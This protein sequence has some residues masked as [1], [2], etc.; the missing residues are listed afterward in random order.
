M[1]LVG[2]GDGDGHVGIWKHG[3]DIVTGMC[4]R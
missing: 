3:A 2:K 1:F 4:S